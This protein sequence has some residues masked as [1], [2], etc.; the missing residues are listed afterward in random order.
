MSPGDFRNDYD[1]RVDQPERD[2]KPRWPYKRRH[3][4]ARP[5][6]LYAQYLDELIAE[7]HRKGTPAPANCDDAYWDERRKNEDEK[8]LPPL[9]ERKAA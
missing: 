5:R 9:F 4:T 1:E 2:D 3:I 6:G 7:S 8:Q